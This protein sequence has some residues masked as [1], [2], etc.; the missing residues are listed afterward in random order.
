MN[1][2]LL[3]TLL[4]FFQ[5][6]NLKA[7]LN[8]SYTIGGASPNFTTFESAAAALSALGISGNVIFNVRPGTYPERF[9]ISQIPGSNLNR[10]VT[11]QA[12]NGDSSSVLMLNT[13]AVSATNY[14]INL[15]NVGQ[16]VIKRLSFQT[17]ETGEFSNAISL[18]NTPNVRLE[19]CHFRGSL[20]TATLNS[21]A[22]ISVIV[23]GIS[24][25]FKAT[26]CF[27]Q[28]GY[29]AIGVLGGQTLISPDILIE[30]NRFVGSIGEAVL[31]FYAHKIKV[32]QNQVD[33]CALG[34]NIRFCS[35]AVVLNNRIMTTSYGGL[36]LYECFGNSNNRS[37]VANNMIAI[38]GTANQA[39]G[40]H[41][42]ACRY[43]D[44]FYNSLNIQAGPQQSYGV[45]LSNSS[46]FIRIQN[47][48]VVVR[49]GGTP[50]KLENEP[51]EVEAYSHCN[52]YNGL[53][54]NDLPPNSISNNPQ[55][56]SP[57]DL[58]VTSTVLN[59]L[60]T[61]LAQV[62]VDF[63]GEIRHV[64]TPDI[65]ADEYTPNLLS[66]GLMGFVNPSVDSVYCSDLPLEVV[67]QNTGTI[68][69]TSLELNVVVNGVAQSSQAW[70]GNLLPGQ[71]IPVELGMFPIVPLQSNSIAVYCNAPNNESDQFQIDDSLSYENLYAP[72]SG[73]YTIGGTNPDFINFTT[74]VEAIKRGGLCGS[75]SFLVRNGT[76]SEQ[77]QLG[78]IKGSSPENWLTFVGE[79][80]DSSLA[81]L[82]APASINL[83]FT[84]RMQNCRFVKFK[85]LKIKQLSNSNNTAAVFIA[86][87]SDLI[88]ENCLIEGHYG[89]STVSSEYALSAFPDSNLTIRNC[90]IWSAKAGAS[91]VGT[92]PIKYN[93]VFE[94]NWVA[95]ASDDG[96][97]LQKWRNVRVHGNRFEAASSSSLY[98]I[99]GLNLNNY[100]I[101]NNQISITGV[102]GTAGIYLINCGNVGLDNSLVTNNAI[103]M[104]L[105]VS[106]IAV[107]RGMLIINCDSVRV[108][109]N[110]IRFN[111]DDLDNLAFEM[112]QTG[113]AYIANNVFANT[114]LGLGVHTFGSEDSEF[115][116]NVYFTNGPLL[117][118]GI[119]DLSGLQALTGGDQNSL[120]ANPMWTNSLPD[121]LALNNPV[122]ENIGT[123]TEVLT[124]ILGF[125]RQFPN[126]DPGA[127]ENPTQPLV[128]L[129]PDQSGC[130]QLTLLGATAGASAYL[131]NT[132]ATTAS[133][134]V[135]A[136][137][138]YSLEASNA[139]GSSIDTI[140]VTIFPLPIVDAGPDLSVCLGDSL[141]FAGSTATGCFWSD[142]SGNPVSD[143]CAFSF[144]VDASNIFI[145]ST[146]DGNQ[147]SA[148]DTLQVTVLDLPNADAGLDFTVCQGDTLTISGT[149]TANCHWVDQDGSEVSNACSFGITALESVTFVLI[150]TDSNHCKAVD[151]MSVDILPN[152]NQPTIVF[153]N[154]LL[155][156]QSNDMVQ[157]WLEG[158]PIPGATGLSF[159]PLVAGNYSAQITNTAGCDVFSDSYFFMVNGTAES[160]EN[161]IQISPNPLTG[162]Q[163]LIRA[164]G[165]FKP[166]YV[167][168]MDAQ[169][170]LLNQ[171]PLCF[172]QANLDSIPIMLEA[173]VYFIRF[174]DGHGQVVLKKLLVL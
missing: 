147:C 165:N 5:L 126:P 115:D 103:S 69:L 102:Q 111:S 44:F 47:N 169:G 56:S 113:G 97:N 101:S 110:S 92:G 91:L 15:Q 6:S 36:S 27:F 146:I 124:D 26:S 2:L 84:L 117:G 40:A 149:S 150:S 1:R 81:V 94:N 46:R 93:L 22:R 122:L 104:N 140:W 158:N 42:Q 86:F 28:A 98:S 75:T 74:A 129:G 4:C 32:Q 68:T 76:Y 11:F 38:L 135:K 58:H 114:G 39:N 144:Q 79:S 24:P 134:T 164:E 171:W 109:H 31:A 166:E 29:H 132:G 73:T 37:L 7:Q 105:G 9:T 151:S 89:N 13:S 71:N 172:Q 133:L 82:S 120:V 51:N 17:P 23:A 116:Y 14:L 138:V 108:L 161:S 159:E 162:N 70:T 18:Y 100:D 41:I 19:N 148:S 168:L 145:L 142:W 137:G 10:S 127:F 57:S 53:I 119:T 35:T 155:S 8:G 107:S 131:W 112:Q 106:N 62:G 20:N 77:I 55:Y 60:G 21:N 152:P 67:L 3:L 66:A 154:G 123:Q 139:L 16:I 59:D 65:G 99:Y 88:F 96:L 45:F 118:H 90:R 43:L 95:G 87:G 174:W 63:D 80:G 136:S 50:V 130:G 48:S 143:S 52:L 153:N 170:R 25:N 121:S 34:F 125:P 78:A 72:L 156:V 167:A 54:I 61:P 141:D 12:E 128:Q 157:W 160:I 85:S 83:A 64:Q 49:A 173:G 30:K 163:L 33:S